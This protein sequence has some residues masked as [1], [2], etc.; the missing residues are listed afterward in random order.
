MN[1]IHIHICSRLRLWIVFVF[2]FVQEKN[3]S[4]HSKF[5]SYSKKNKKKLFFF[6]YLP[7][8]EIF[9][10]HFSD[11]YVAVTWDLFIV[12]YSKIFEYLNIFK[13]SNIFMNI[14]QI[15]FLLIFMTQYVKKNI[16]ICIHIICLLQIIFI[17]VFVHQKNHSLHSGTMSLALGLT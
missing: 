6:K 11:W 5:I 2:V 15:T 7:W 13:Y 8:L 17:C 16:Y 12:K 1:N 3:Y 9:Y 10:P 4:L 14:S